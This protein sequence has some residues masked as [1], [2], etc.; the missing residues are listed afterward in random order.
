MQVGNW[1]INQLPPGYV[2]DLISR[3]PKIELCN[4]SYAEKKQR[5]NKK[6]SSNKMEENILSRN[7]S[8]KHLKCESSDLRICI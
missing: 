6:Q 7:I 8:G 2:N 4:T 1:L 3:I 5:D